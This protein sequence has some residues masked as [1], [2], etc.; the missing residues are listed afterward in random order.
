MSARTNALMLETP[1]K[2]QQVSLH[3]IADDARSKRPSIDWRLDLERAKLLTESYK[4]TEGEPMILRRAKAL[5]HILRHMTLFIRSGEL[6]VGNFSSTLDSVC[7]YPEMAWKWVE[8]ETAPGNIYSDLLDDEGRKQLKEINT[9]W[10]K[11]AVHHMLK[12]YLPE[13]LAGLTYLFNWESCTPNYDKIFK[14][15]LKGI[16][17][18]TQERQKRLD[19]DYM[20][21]AINGEDFITMKDFLTSVFISLDAVILWSKRYAKLAKEMAEVEQNPAKRNDLEQIS[22]N[23]QWVPENPPRTLH[24]ALQCFWFIHLIVNFI[25]L[26]QVGCGIRFDVSF[27]PFY[28]KDV[29][30]GLVNRDLAQEI[31]ECVFVK[32]QETGF[33]HPP[34]WSGAGGGGLGFQTV[35]IGG[36]D[37]VGNDITNEMTYIVLD[38]MNSVRTVAPPLALRW[39]DG[40]PK[41]LIDKTIEVLATGMPQP[42]IFNDKVNVLR[43]TDLGFPLKDARNYSINNCMVPTVPG[44]NFNHRGAWASAV[45]MPA[46]LLTALGVAPPMISFF[47]EK[48]TAKRTDPQKITSINELM[49]AVIENYEYIVHRLVLM[50]NIGDAL[51]KNYLPRPFLSAVIDDGIEK[52]QDV[53]GWN[54]NPDYRDVVILGLNNVTDSLAAIKKLVFEEKKIGMDEL[55][56]ALKN[57]W[58][59]YEDMR[60]IC[61]SAPKFGNDDDYVDWISLELGKRIKEKTMQ[62]KTNLGTPVIPDGTVAS[63]FYYMG[64]LCGATPDGRGAGENFHDGS[65]S[66]MGGTDKLGPTAVLKSVSKV[67]PLL[68]WNH[69]FNQSFMPQYLEGPNAEMFA[70]Y[71]KT[72][73][74]LGIHHIQFSVVGRAALED[75]QQYPEKHPDQMVRVAGYSAYFI[76]LCKDLQDQIISRTPQCL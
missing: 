69:L 61:L 12:R 31:V 46:C 20:A 56:K 5:A 8:R 33:L 47:P 42:A 39:H 23:C 6:I 15:G 44:K 26:P 41:R 45:S 32:F 54:Y 59:G 16:I 50:S 22:K 68:T 27:N 21:G 74:D 10:D 30:D 14:I 64:R 76:D 49:D 71:L 19:K 29:K 60:Q 38:A 65:I 55:I 13:D 67:D 34:V 11:L 52:A 40:I 43:L 9:Y 25:E 62:F 37:T 1:V 7:Y 53:R 75:A 3:R 58:A 70:Q 63:A 66:P 72:F 18:E 2:T 51:Y 35:T 17:K 24:E 28:E 57:N 36:T 73:S 48:T 4:E